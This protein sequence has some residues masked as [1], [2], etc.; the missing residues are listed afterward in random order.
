M[1]V[2][3]GSGVA[4]AV[5]AV[6][7]VSHGS[8]TSRPADVM[9]SAFLARGPSGVDAETNPAASRRAMEGYTE[10]V[11]EL[12]VGV[13]DCENSFRTSYADSGPSRPMIAR[14]V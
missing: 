8:S 4:A 2:R 6:M 9:L 7:V 10:P 14:M 11:L 13:I 1:R 5:V 12:Q 3:T